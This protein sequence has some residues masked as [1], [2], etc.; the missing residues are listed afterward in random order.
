MDNLVTNIKELTEVDITGKGVFDQLMQATINHIDVE[1]GRNRIKGSEYSTVYLGA[2][3]SVLSESI[4]FLL[5][6]NNIELQ[7]AQIRLIE[8]QILKAKQDTI[9]AGRQIKLTDSQIK[10]SDAGVRKT[11][12]ET[13]LIEQ[14]RKNEET[15]NIVLLEEIKKLQAE[16]ALLAQKRVTEEAQTNGDVIDPESILGRQREIYRAQAEGFGQEA[17]QK[18]GKL[19]IDAWNVQRST[20]PGLVKGIRFQ[21]IEA[22]V[23]N[24]LLR[25]GA[26]V[27]DYSSVDNS[28]Y[29]T[30][31]GDGE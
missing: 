21:D 16:N 17:A 10:M 15:Q 23:A 28:G 25:S 2:L 3:Q 4:R 18:T 29:E 19:L 9:L 22:A 30:E 27:P 8:E 5:E 13:K 24:T 11:E 1:F 6:R 12:T 14:Q 31:A 26:E 7:D 20:L